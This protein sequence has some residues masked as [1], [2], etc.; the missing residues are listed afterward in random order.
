M[1][2]DHVMMTPNLDD[3][4]L[5]FVGGP[6]GFTNEIKKKQ[7]YN[8][9]YT[10]IIIGDL[11]NLQDIYSNFDMIYF[12]VFSQD[13]LFRELLDLKKWLYD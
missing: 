2:G 12:F 4:I 3:F 5:I 13:F 8:N 1:G 9:L 11:S 10:I 6:G 7:F